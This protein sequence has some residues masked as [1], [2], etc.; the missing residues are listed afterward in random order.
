M[1]GFVGLLLAVPIAAAIAV[2]FRFGLKRYLASPIYTGGQPSLTATADHAREPRQLALALDHAESFAREDFLG[3]PSNAS[4]LAL[5]DPWPDW[6]SRAV[7]LSGPEGSGKSHLA[8]I[9]GAAAGA[10]FIAARALG[11]AE[12]PAALATGALVIEDAAAGGYRRAGAVSSPQSGA[13]G[14][15]FVLIT[16]RTAP[17]GW[18]LRSATSARG[19]RRCPWSRCRRPAMTCC[20]RCW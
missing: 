3:G 12:V 19:S 14:G 7:V 8:A 13:R 9:W 5:I 6:A 1:F 16:A 18:R 17:A 4:A 11:E 20:A 2:L 15:A 10:R